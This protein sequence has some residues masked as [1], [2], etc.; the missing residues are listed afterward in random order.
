VLGRK[1]SLSEALSSR[2]YLSQCRFAH[3]RSHGRSHGGFPI[4]KDL[5]LRKRAVNVFTAELLLQ[6][7]DDDDDLLSP[8]LNRDLTR[9]FR[10]GFA[11]LRGGS[12]IKPG[13]HDHRAGVLS[14]EGPGCPLEHS[15]LP[16]WPA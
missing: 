2:S 8:D 4:P 10:L 16:A 15:V 14:L 6:S 7:D 9:R 12:R 11:L 1:L 13:H 3:C 5:G